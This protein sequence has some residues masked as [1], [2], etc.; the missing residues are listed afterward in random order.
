MRLSTLRNISIM[1]FVLS[2]GGAFSAATARGQDIFVAN[3]GGGTIGEYT[4]SGAVVNTSLIPGLLPYGPATL[5]VSGS[6]LFVGNFGDGT[7]GEYN[8]SIGEYTT[9]GEV[10][11]ASLIPGLL[12]GEPT[13]MVVSGSMQ[14]NVWLGTIGR[15]E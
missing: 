11:N 2:V 6:N 12:R 8:G 7:P 3:Y 9:S 14:C 4:T 10:V 5:A 13:G 1:A 15:M